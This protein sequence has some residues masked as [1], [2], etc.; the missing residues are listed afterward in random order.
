MSVLRAFC[1]FCALFP[2]IHTAGCVNP[3]SPRVNFTGL[4]GKVAPEAETLY[5]KARVLWSKRPGLP[6]G[7]E[8]CS[9]PG[10]AA[11][12]L[13]AALAREPQYADAYA[14]RGLA[15][16]ELGEH[17]AAFEDLTAALRLHALPEYYAYR[18]LVLLRAGNT[19]GSRKD[20]RQSLDLD[21]SQ[22]LAWNIM[23]ALEFLTGNKDAACD[24]YDEAC[25]NGDCSAKEHARKE[26]LCP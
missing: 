10:K 11:A 4:S 3:A 15:R 19:T 22:Y 21:D 25:S 13:D 6:A 24:S 1:L 17:D 9:D 14:R 23:G 18:G 8:T 7:T 20:L 26:R 2:L 5:S 16:S 12:F